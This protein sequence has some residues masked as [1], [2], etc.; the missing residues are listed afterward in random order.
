MMAI[1]RRL[2]D[3]FPDVRTVDLDGRAVIPGLIDAHGHV[4][5]L[6]LARLPADELHRLRVLVTALDG[7]PVYRADDAP[8]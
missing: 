7:E 6:G 4:M 8:M 3:W 5:G 2:P 1:P